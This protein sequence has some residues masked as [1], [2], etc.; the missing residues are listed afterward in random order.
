MVAKLTLGREFEASPAALGG[1]VLP[2]CGADSLA[3][4]WW[5][6]GVRGRLISLLPEQVRLSATAIRAE[7]SRD[8]ALNICC[9]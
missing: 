2:S 5:S 4:T 1:G 6:A 7:E 9:M 8:L 3:G